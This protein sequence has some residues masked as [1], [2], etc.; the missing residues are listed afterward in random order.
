MLAL[1][2]VFLAYFSATALAS[3][4]VRD[5]TIT[6]PVNWSKPVIFTIP[7]SYLVPYTGLYMSNISDC[8]VILP[9]WYGVFGDQVVVLFDPEANLTANQPVTFYL[10]YGDIIHEPDLLFTNMTDVSLNASYEGSLSEDTGSTG[11]FSVPS[12]RTLEDFGQRVWVENTTITI[13]VSPNRRCDVTVEIYDPVTG[14]TYYSNTYYSTTWVSDQ[15]TLRNLAV[16][17]LAVRVDLSSGNGYAYLSYDTYYGSPGTNTSSVTING[18]G[19]TVWYIILRSLSTD[20]KMVLG[21]SVT[22]RASDG[23]G[24]VISNGQLG[25]EQCSFPVGV[26]FSPRFWGYLCSEQTNSQGVEVNTSSVGLSVSVTGYDAWAALSARVDSVEALAN[27]SI[28]ISGAHSPVPPGGG[29]SGGGGTGGG[30]SGGTGGNTTQVITVNVEARSETYRAVAMGFGAG[31]SILSLFAGV[32]ALIKDRLE[33]A[34]LGVVAG[35]WS[36]FFFNYV[37]LPKI[38]FA[39]AAIGVGV[40]AVALIDR[41]IDYISS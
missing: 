26:L 20:G 40:S 27:A 17:G 25:G 30:S 39:A 12:T 41:V 11:W 37:L 18:T 4:L 34:L 36:G 15:V 33:Y 35:F 3:T 14:N 7:E 19:D 13:Y 5:V 6:P 9:T 1:V 29:G 21:W 32:Y 2:I 16:Y 24:I 10:C 23:T 38:G 28:V 31:L 22:T 8:S